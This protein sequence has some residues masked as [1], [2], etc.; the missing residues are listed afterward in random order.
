MAAAPRTCLPRLPQTWA[1]HCK[2]ALRAYF[3]SGW[4]FFIP[5][6]L[7]YQLYAWMRWPASSGAPSDGIRPSFIPSLLVVYWVLHCAHVLLAAAALVSWWRG[8]SNRSGA[9][10]NE[11]PKDRTTAVDCPPPVAP[12]SPFSVAW[13][14]L[15]WICL[16]LIFSIP[17]VYL[18]WPS[19]PW[20]HLRRITEWQTHAFV[21]EHSAGYKS[22]Y[23][24]VYSLVG[25]MSPDPLLACIEIYYIAICLCLAWQ[26]YL[27]ARAV[28]L[29]AQWAFAFVVVGAVTFGNSSFSYYRYYGLATTILA[30]IAA[31]ALTRNFLNWHS[32]PSRAERSVDFA[33]P[34]VWTL[35]SRSLTCALLLALIACSHV[36]GLGI[37]ALG[38]AAIAIWRLIEWRRSMV[39]WIL[40]ALVLLSTLAVV[41]WPRHWMIDAAYRRFGWMNAWYGFDILSVGSGAFERTTQI[42]G[43][44]GLANL[45]A[46]LWLLRRNNIV[47][48]LTIIPVAALLS[49]LV[50]IP[51]AN[52][53]AEDNSIIVFHRMF[54]GVPC[55]LALVCVAQHPIGRRNHSASSPR[56]IRRSSL[57][58]ALLTLVALT[59]LSPAGSSF[60]RLWHLLAPTPHDLQAHPVVVAAL[61]DTAQTRSSMPLRLVA[62][63][64]IATVFNTVEPTVYPFKQRTTASIPSKNLDLLTDLARSAG[65]P[66][67]RQNIPET[68]TRDPNASQ[69]D[70]WTTLAGL[71]PEFV[72]VA[73]FCTAGT[74]LQNPPGE[75]VY[76]FTL[77]LIPIETTLRYRVEMSLRLLTG[78]EAKCYLAVAWYDENARLLISNIPSPN[79]AGSPLGWA[80]GSYSYFG[81]VGEKSP[82]QWTT[83]RTSFG[84]NEPARV[85]AN[86]R[87]ARLGA[88]LNYDKSPTS[89]LQLTNVR[90]WLKTPHENAANGRFLCHEE[91][92]V[93]APHPSRFW[94][95]TS[96]AA[97]ASGHWLPRQVHLDFAGASDLGTIARSAGPERTDEN[98][99]V[100]LFRPR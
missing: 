13:R 50:A 62:P 43:V 52:Q 4:A 70:A 8:Q 78:V 47:G 82:S 22:F 95:W 10:L 46:G 36:Q 32:P 93:V 77:E 44:A 75:A 81:L 55:G 96:F 5:Y 31:I 14:F 17:G 74:A 26:Y 63:D 90:L 40:G 66:L 83:F 33:H 42:F 25:W 79:G 80:N 58:A 60:I 87:F 100:F 37:A 97:Q 38:I 27:L 6:L 2:P 91:S 56:P 19:D 94:S 76:V 72:S 61:S 49:P 59:L 30:Q 71:R 15:P 35:I 67:H 73:D 53:L 45:V 54:L 51:F 99:S 68:L 92:L 9:H 12:G 29:D 86:A 7:T 16:A 20:E 84:P 65:L 23:F 85:P 24:L 21:S 41:W 3:R 57:G 34:V 89:I 28:G 69:P 18:E 11:G 1:N 48:W 39:F 88:L 64:S 98:N